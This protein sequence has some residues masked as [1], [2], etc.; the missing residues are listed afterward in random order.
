MQSTRRGAI[1]T[2][3]GAVGMMLAS[4]FGSP[5]AEG[6][7]HPS[8]QPLPSPNAPTNMN[9][10]I[11]L[12]QEDIPIR[13]P[14]NLIPPATWKE[15]KDDAQRLYLMSASFAT[16]VDNTNISVTLPVSLLKE[17]RAIEKMAKHIQQRMK[18]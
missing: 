15:I 8:P 11:Q 7:M 3:S 2:M 10:P 17:A 5:A 16:Q 4:R 1:L 9:A 13:G 6:Q 18:T 12:D 14:G